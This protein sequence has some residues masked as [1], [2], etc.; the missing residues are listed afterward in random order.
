[1]TTKKQYFPGKVTGCFFLTPPFDGC[2][3]KIRIR[4]SLD[5]QYVNECPHKDRSTNVCA[6]CLVMHTV[7]C[8]SNSSDLDP[9]L[10][11]Y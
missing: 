8:P 10:N 7:L 11:G 5:M 9:S 4:I 2:E 6:A 3:V 1:M